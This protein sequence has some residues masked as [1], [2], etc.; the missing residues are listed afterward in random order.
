MLLST[1]YWNLIVGSVFLVCTLKCRRKLLATANRFV[2]P[3]LSIQS[4]D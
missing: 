4:Y 2:Q 1:G 3:R